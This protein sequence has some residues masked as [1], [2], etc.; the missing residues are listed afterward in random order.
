[1]FDQRNSSLL[2]WLL[3]EY[4]GGPNGLGSDAVDFVFLDDQWSPTAGPSEVG[5]NAVALMGLSKTDVQVL[6]AAYWK[7]MRGMQEGIVK[8]GGFEWHS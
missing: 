2:A 6:N 8:M 3:D 4:I 7:N 5:P 1:M